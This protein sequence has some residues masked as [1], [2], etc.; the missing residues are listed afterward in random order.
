[1]ICVPFHSLFHYSASTG[2][3]TLLDRGQTACGCFRVAAQPESSAIRKLEFPE[4][5]ICDQFEKNEALTLLPQL[6]ALPM[7][8]PR[9]IQ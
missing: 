8:E 6:S 7:I 4:F 9:D 5:G 1:M 2:S 3:Q